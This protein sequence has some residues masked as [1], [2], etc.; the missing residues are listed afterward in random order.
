MESTHQLAVA[1]AHAI[2]QHNYA[3]AEELYRQVIKKLEVESSPKNPDELDFAHCLN[4]LAY[5]LE[6]QDKTV[7][8]AQIKNRVIEI[9]AKELNDIDGFDR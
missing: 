9:T 5:A 7:E 8:A 1:A 4:S 3:Q 2:C 6:K